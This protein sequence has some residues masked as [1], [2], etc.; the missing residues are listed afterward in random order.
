MPR[1]PFRSQPGSE[2]R[3]TLTVENRDATLPESEPFAF[4]G[5][6]DRSRRGASQIDP[7]PTFRLERGA[8]E[9]R[10]LGTRAGFDTILPAQSDL[11]GYD[12]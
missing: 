11:P 4:S 3:V 8:L 10:L 5:E 12:R 7:K 1:K 2:S 9:L 6:I